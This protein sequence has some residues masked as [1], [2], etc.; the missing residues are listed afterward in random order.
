MRAPLFHQHPGHSTSL[1][2]F[3][4]IGEPYF[5]PAT[6]DANMTKTGCF[7]Q[8]KKGGKPPRFARR[9]GSVRFVEIFFFCC[10]QHILRLKALRCCG[11]SDSFYC[12][13][14][15][16]VACEEVVEV[17]TFSVGARAFPCVCGSWR[18]IF[19]VIRLLGRASH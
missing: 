9:F 1:G 14:Q 7:R 18:T 19:G 11:K 13:Q 16:I 10:C 4:M 2:S 6:R 15:S 17:L 8:S 12:P 5:A 3:R